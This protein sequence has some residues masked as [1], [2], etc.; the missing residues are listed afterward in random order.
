MIK[1][2]SADKLR[3]N[4]DAAFTIDT[5]FLERCI[6]TLDKAFHLL[7]KVDAESLEY[8]LYRSAT[9][10]EFEI[11]LEQ[12]GSLLRKRLKPYFHSSK[13]VARLNFKD[14]FR[15]AGH[16]DLLSLETVERWLVY[17]DNRNST[18]HDYG[19][20]LAEKTLPLMPQFIVDADDLVQAIN[21][22]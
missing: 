20:G 15:Y 16:H 5:A 8:D 9:I 7:Q 17:R 19:L 14:V 11:I 3:E 10:K 13:A 1:K 6:Q 18:A 4:T 12:S 22:K 2:K 21:K